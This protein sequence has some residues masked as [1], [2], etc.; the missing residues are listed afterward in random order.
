ML[1]S[2]TPQRTQKILT[3]IKRSV[4][5]ASFRIQEA[6]ITTFTAASCGQCASLQ[7][8]A[9]LKIPTNALNNCLNNDRRVFNPHLTS[10]PS[11]YGIQ[12]MSYPKV[13]LAYAVLQ[14][15]RLRI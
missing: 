1:R 3:T 6:Y 9:P 14:Y 11:L 10:P 8:S 15:H 4:T 7:A 5:R 12:M 2:Y 13:K